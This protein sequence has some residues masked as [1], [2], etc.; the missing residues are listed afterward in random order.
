MTSTSCIQRKM[1]VDAMLE[2]RSGIQAALWAKVKV[3]TKNAKIM[4]KMA[5]DAARAALENAH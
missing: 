1:A 2:V 4:P 3:A 5:E